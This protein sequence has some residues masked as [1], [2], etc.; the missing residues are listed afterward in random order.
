MS[1]AWDEFEAEYSDL[2]DDV[3]RANY[4]TYEQKLR[5]FIAHIDS[6]DWAKARAS[7]LAPG[8]DFT[9]WY[10]DA[11]ESVGSMVGSGT[12][13]WVADRKVRLGQQLALFRHFSANDDA[14]INFASDFMYAGSRF[15]D[16]I[17][18][19]N[20]QLFEPFARDL[21]KDIF[22]HS[23]LETKAAEVPASDHIVP[24]DHNSSAYRQL[25]N[26][27]EALERAV[28]TSNALGAESPDER[29]RVVAEISATRRILKAA[30][31]R[32]E[33]V[34]ALIVPSLK[35]IGSKIADNAVQI[36]ITAV[37]AALAA[38]FGIAIPGL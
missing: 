9:S 26:N 38:M 16:M 4:T 19:I 12:L 33:A 37:V 18:E 34:C 25:E 6:C 2:A 20:G 32:M 14:Y 36:A 31:A 5:D 21:L 13:N 22:K 15:D 27:L 23:P 29:D 1:M 10:N 24:I 3:S 17:R 30:R 11:R 35:W 28:Q 8:F 7:Q